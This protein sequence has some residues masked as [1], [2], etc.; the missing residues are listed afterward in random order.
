[1]YVQLSERDLEEIAKLEAGSNTTA[2]LGLE[3]DAKNKATNALLTRY[4]VAATPSTRRDLTTAT[5]LRTPAGGVGA[6]VRGI[7]RTPARTP[8]R[9]DT[10]LSE[11]Q[12]ILALHN[13]NTP[14][15]GGENQPLQSSDFS[16]ATPQR[17]VAQTPNSL[18][19]PLRRAFP[20][21]AAAG[22]G[23]G[24][25][26]VSRPSSV[27]RSL[28]T[29]TPVRDELK[30]NDEKLLQAEDSLSEERQKQ[31]MLQRHV[32]AGLSKLP[33]A[34]NEYQI[35]LPNAA[36]ADDDAKDIDDLTPDSAGK[37]KIFI[38]FLT[39]VTEVAFVFS[40]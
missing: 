9:P 22:G 40:I 14:L 29:R 32:Q 5:P 4:D 2:E 33:E 17:V 28:L 10:L 26:S 36:G 24:S 25:A 30:L 38:Y 19:T 1:M 15:I 12:N 20:A 21:G 11:A 23:G 16:G 6:S 39:R 35:V 7:S 37:E 18:T 13:T 34:K 8:A 3:P 31:K 27:L